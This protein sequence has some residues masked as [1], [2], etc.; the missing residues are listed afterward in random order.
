MEK[1]FI[2]KGNLNCTIEEHD[3]K[4]DSYAIMKGYTSFGKII[5]LSLAYIINKLINKC[6]KWLNLFKLLS[7]KP[8]IIAL[9]A[10]TLMCSV[11]YKI[12]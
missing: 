12:S 10:V 5:G 2:P 7:Q 6:Y 1:S 3:T 11:L 9:V 4:L 8:C